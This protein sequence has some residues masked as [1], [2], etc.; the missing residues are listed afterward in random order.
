VWSDDGWLR[1]GL[2]RPRSRLESFLL[3]KIDFW[4]RLI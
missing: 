2:D 1:S 3:L 4:C